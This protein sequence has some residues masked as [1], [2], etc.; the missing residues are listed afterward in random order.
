MQELLPLNGVWALVLTCG[1]YIFGLYLRKKSGSAICNPTLISAII[2]I[3]F[4]LLSGIPN[5]TYQD[6]MKLSSWLLTPCTVCLGISF[7]TQLQRMK[8]KL[9]AIFIGVGAGALSS[10]VMI[11]AACIL[12]KLDVSIT[13]SLLPKSITTAMAIPLVEPTSGYVSVTTA[14]IIITG[15]GGSM[16]G[17]Y[18]CKLLRIT[19]PIAQGVAFGTASH[20]MGTSRATE[21]NELSGAVGSLSL[22]VAGILTAVLFNPALQFFS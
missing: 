20:V 3:G 1:A 10:L 16:V 6:G 9:M 5:Q 12:L 19:D 18:L 13:A 4:L 7:Y 17:Q 15:I 21:L 11:G 8:G 22:C 14:A 2:I